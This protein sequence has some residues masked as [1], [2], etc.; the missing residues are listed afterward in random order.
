MYL[1]SVWRRGEHGRI[2]DGTWVLEMAADN[3][4][5]MQGRGARSR[6]PA[7]AP[8]GGWSLARRHSPPSPR[9]GRR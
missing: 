1:R 5:A 2:I 9:G 7:A 4:E 3:R 8:E 6:P